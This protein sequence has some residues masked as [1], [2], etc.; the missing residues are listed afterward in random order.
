MATVEECRAALTEL[1]SRF[2]EID[3][4]DRA[5]HVVDRTVSCY[6][7]D[8]DTT[9]HGRIQRGRLDILDEDEADDT[10]ADIGLTMSGDDLIKL[11]NGE[12]D[13]ARALLSGRV[14]INASFGDMLRL[15]RLL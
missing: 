3:A 5:K 10:A 6:L 4:A 7:T 2:D 11:V 13:M 9:F 12:L 15:R 1:V 8:L 14:K